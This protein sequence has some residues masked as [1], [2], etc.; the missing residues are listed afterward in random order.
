VL[1]FGLPLTFW[2]LPT[3]IGLPFLIL[4]IIRFAPQAMASSPESQER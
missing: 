4:S 1:I 2:V 3:L